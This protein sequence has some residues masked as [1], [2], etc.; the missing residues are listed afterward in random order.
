M[1]NRILN[2]LSKISL[3]VVLILFWV[4]M[5]IKVP[6]LFPTNTEAFR[7]IILTYI[8]FATLVFSFDAIS[9]RRTER[10]LF[11]IGFLKAFPKFLIF[12]GIGLGVL[13]LF[14]LA[15]KGDALPTIFD[16][17]RNV[18]IGV[19]LL[20]AFFVATLEEK[21]FRSWLVNELRARRIREG[22]AWTISVLVFA[23]FHYMLNGEWLT[24]AIYIPL[25][26]IFLVVRERY[27]P[28]T[29]MANSG[30]HFAWNMFIL[31]FL[32]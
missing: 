19:I 16:A 3:G 18:G 8:I 24:L 2:Q 26:F 4:W 32:V 30:L 1:A 22:F 31:G 20:H 27:S 25:G 5:W 29:D 12:A 13:F 21:V 15:I 28:R 17:V 9:S 10:P 11:Q 14:G 6:Q 7:N 23:F